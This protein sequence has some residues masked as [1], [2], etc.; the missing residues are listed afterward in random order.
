MEDVKHKVLFDLFASPGTLVPI[1]AGVTAWLYSW[2]VGGSQVAGSVGLFGVLGGIGFFATRAIWGLEKMTQQAYE[3]LTRQ[4]IEAQERSLN[5][6]LLRLI[7]DEDPRTEQILQDLRSLHQA[8]Q[9]DVQS[10]TIIGV[11]H[12]LIEQVEQ[13]FTASVQQLTR[14]LDLYETSQKLSPKVRQEIL[15]ERQ[16]VIDEVIQTRD[17]LSKSIEQFQ[18]F[19]SKRNES[20]LGLL[21]RELEETLKVA[22]RTEERMAQLGQ[23]GRS[24]DESE[25]EP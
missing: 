10:R 12:R 8:F 7:D 16:R 17:H 4:Q 5:H 2:A 18:A 13:I 24:Y 11:Q 21:R 25:F 6:L 19:N 22:K 3:D 15:R 20:E 14:S 23:R 1:V 9:L